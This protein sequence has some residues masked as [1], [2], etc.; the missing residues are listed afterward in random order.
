MGTCKEIKR[1]GNQCN[2]FCIKNSNFCFRHSENYKQEALEASRKGGYNRKDKI[3]VGVNITIREP[4][5]VK[6]FL[7]KLIKLTG[8][9]E[10]PTS[11]AV[12]MGSLCKMYLEA[13]SEADLKRR[14]D[15]MEKQLSRIGKK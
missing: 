1:D 13:Y 3:S 4:E 6:K 15:L 8:S 2:A 14:V 7:A 11:D 10:L 5:D 9:G 12:R